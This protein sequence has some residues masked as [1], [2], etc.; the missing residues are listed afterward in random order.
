MWKNSGIKKIR[1]LEMILAVLQL[2]LTAIV[3]GLAFELN[4]FPN[5]YLIPAGIIAVLLAAFTFFTQWAGKLSKTGKVVSILMCI[6]LIIGSNYL[7]KM[8][9]MLS[10]VLSD[11]KQLDNVLVLVRSGDPAEKI[12]DANNYTFGIQKEIDRDN[13]NKTIQKLNNNLGVDIKTKEYS[14]FSDQ[15][16][17]LCD[18]EV[19]AII[20]NENLRNIFWETTDWNIFLNTRVIASNQIERDLNIE[21]CTKNV[22]EEPFTV[23]ISGKDGYS[24]DKDADEIA[25]LDTGFS[26]VN[27]I[28]TIN[29]KTKKILLLT[30][31]RDTYVTIPNSGGQKD[32]LTRA[33]FWG[34][35]SSMA[36]LEEL[37]GINIDYYVQVDF[38]SLTKI[39]DALG[40][41]DVVSDYSFTTKGTTFNAGVNQLNGK[42]ALAFARERRVFASQ[43]MQ[44]SVNTLRLLEG[45]LKKCDSPA[46]LSGA[47]EIIASVEEDFD[48]NI[49][50][51]DIARLIK[52]M[53]DNGY[54][55]KINGDIIGGEGLMTTDTYTGKGHSYFVMIPDEKLVEHEKLMMQEIME[56]K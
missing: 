44:R 28:A 49:S 52:I 11:G 21:K 7:Y 14:D 8:N 46:I 29:P 47:E 18:G 54:T 40:G 5:K 27:I 33:G 34:V 6:F 56:G 41:I 15:M 51:K 2:S 42:E 22:A 20:L 4:I 16:H 23:Y 39:V 55:W 25:A 48:A 43:D 24:L 3:L 50:K 26:D 32:K 19:K 13:T 9:C 36:T 38:A 12:D 45:I 1:K 30:T 17:A 31:P 35:D 37:Y 53:T 10:N